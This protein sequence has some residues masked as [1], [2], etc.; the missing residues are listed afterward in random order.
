[1]FSLD[2]SNVLFHHINARLSWFI[3]LE[4][5]GFVPFY[6]DPFVLDPATLFDL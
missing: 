1:M 4:F 3:F 6:Y 2:W 5:N